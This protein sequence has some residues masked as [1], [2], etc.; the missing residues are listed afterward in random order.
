MIDA[1]VDSGEGKA[2]TTLMNGEASIILR[3][4]P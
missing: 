1:S 4:A 2:F 3:I